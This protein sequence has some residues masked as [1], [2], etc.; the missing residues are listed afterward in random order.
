MIKKTLFFIILFILNYSSSFA[1]LKM[2]STY[3]TFKSSYL[4]P[5]TDNKSIYAVNNNAFTLNNK[6]K[7]M[8][9]SKENYNNSGS[10]NTF[11]YRSIKIGKQLVLSQG[12]GAILAFGSLLAGA[13]ITQGAESLALYIMY[14]GYMAGMTLGIHYFGNDKYEQAGF[15][16]SLLGA[17]IGLP[18]GYLIYKSDPKPHGFSAAAPF[19]FPTLGAVISFNLSAKPK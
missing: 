7:Y 5:Q 6:L 14:G 3:V 4:L 11:G 10:Y 16:K 19:I 12:S 18:I 1:Q 9:E 2:R 15:G 17:L 8:S 13:I